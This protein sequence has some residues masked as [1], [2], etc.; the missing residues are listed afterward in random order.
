MTTELWKDIKNYEAIYQVSDHGQIRR[1]KGYRCKKQRL[2]KPKYVNKYPS[3][4]L[5]NNGL[6]KNYRM[7]TLVLNTFIGHKP[8]GMECR[9]L[10]GNPVNNKLSNL[11]WG[12]HSENQQDSI[13]HGTFF[14]PDNR[15]EKHNMVKLTDTKVMEIRYLLILGISH[16]QIAK[17]FNVNPSTIS[18]INTCKTWKHLS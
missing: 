8:K 14:H 16:V 3:V 18:H 11:K 1:L 10:D 17:Q 2:L 12:T 7:H 6:S 15:G 13:K 5:C 9:H 4:D